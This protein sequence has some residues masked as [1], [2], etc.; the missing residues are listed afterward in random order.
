MQNSGASDPGVTT[1]MT[2]NA[3]DNHVGT[4]V[5]DNPVLFK[6]SYP[7]SMSRSGFNDTQKHIARGH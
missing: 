3:N 1:T 7:K 2:R 6:T 4:V 5:Y